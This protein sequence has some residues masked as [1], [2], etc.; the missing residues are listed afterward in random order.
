MGRDATSTD[1]KNSDRDP[2]EPQLEGGGAGLLDWKPARWALIYGLPAVTCLLAGAAIYVSRMGVEQDVHLLAQETWVA[3]RKSAVRVVAY[4]STGQPVSKIFAALSL[5][6]EGQEP[7]ELGSTGIV[8]VPAL[9]LE[10]QA[11]SWPDGSYDLV[12]SVET[13]AADETIR[14]PIKIVS[15]PPDFGVLH[16][17]RPPPDRTGPSLTKGEVGDVT[18]ELLPR[19]AGLVPN[20]ANI[21]FLRTTKSDGSPISTQ[22]GLTLISGALGE[23]LPDSVT[24]D[25][26]GLAV[27]SLYP[28]SNDLA[29]EVSLPELAH[30]EAGSAALDGGLGVDGGV[31]T[32]DGG[33]DADVEASQPLAKLY[34]PTTPAQ[35]VMRADRPTVEASEPIDVRL[36]SLHSAR[37]VYVDGYGGNGRWVAAKTG[38]FQRS[39]AQVRLSGLP[40]GVALV[41]A[42][43]A[44]LEVGY[45][46]AAHHVF[47][48]ESG[49]D[50]ESTLVA[51]AEA[52]RERDVEVEYVNALLDRGLLRKTRRF[53]LTAAFL[54]SRL[55]RG[56][57]TPPLRVSSQSVRSA[58]LAQFQSSFRLRI[59]IAIGILG[60][61]VAG[62][63]AYSFTLAAWR[64][65]AQRKMMEADLGADENELYVTSMGRPVGLE[66]FRVVMQIALMV[67]VVAA[68]FLLIAVLVSTLYW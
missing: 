27:L 15:E 24:T 3:G 13:P 6:G 39:K 42:Y 20:L 14:T 31:S 52:L 40:A 25:E 47:V 33:A 38:R 7:V 61:L 44:T 11:P 53:E 5:E 50:E 54:L 9:D 34:V 51:I 28:Q 59:S 35:L 32:V 26:L 48:Q 18:V 21:L 22:V 8:G 60:L 65:R 2:L 46:Y 62:L 41:Q 29:V 58:E 12:V 16:L 30:A 10:V 55:D 19:G 43:T 4:D 64:A 49:R 23:P 68:G 36:Q 37:P 63:L 56:Y 66:R 45:G 57:R 67:G 17:P 1:S